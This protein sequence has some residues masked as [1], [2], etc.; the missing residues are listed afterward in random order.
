VVIVL[1][2]G[3]YRLYHAIANLTNYVKKKFQEKCQFEKYMFYYLQYL[4]N[5]INKNYIY[6]PILERNEIEDILS[7]LKEY[8]TI[9]KQNMSLNDIREY[10]TF[11]FN[12]NHITLMLNNTTVDSLKNV[13]SKM[14]SK[15][16]EE[17][18]SVKLS[19]I[20][21]ILLCMEYN[22][23]SKDEITFLIFNN[24]YFIMEE[25]KN[26]HNIKE[27]FEIKNP[28][29][30]INNNYLVLKVKIN[31]NAFLYY[32]FNYY[33]NEY[34]I[35]EDREQ[36]IEEIKKGYD[37]FVAF[38]SFKINKKE[39]YY[40]EITQIIEELKFKINYIFSHSFYDKYD[41]FEEEMILNSESDR[42]VLTKLMPSKSNNI[43]DFY[44]DSYYPNL[45][46][47]YYLSLI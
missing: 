13:V 8:V 11:D 37:R 22:F 45:V 43:L 17:D 39:E 41:L 47:T 34:A 4:R 42:K 3:L 36:Q 2:F 20:L 27:L 21:F 35:E 25:G 46:Y 5:Q 9:E 29:L 15:G 31:Y 26:I 6:I 32:L 14:I 7:K 33:F 28:L 38:N 10:L 23:Y 16:I 1:P 30:D 19:D 40:F 12:T 44:F 24:F 18:G